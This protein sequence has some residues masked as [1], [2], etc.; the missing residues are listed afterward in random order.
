MHFRKDALFLCGLRLACKVTGRRV[1]IASN[2][3]TYILRL[4][5]VRESLF[6]S[7]KQVTHNSRSLPVLRGTHWHLS[8][9]LSSILA[10]DT[11]STIS[12]SRNAILFS[13]SL[14]LQT[15]D[16]LGLTPT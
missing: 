7:T 1:E 4:R 2:V 16:V 9:S 13:R 14:A 5:K 3:A 12:F 10:D 8:I 15:L 11:V 6:G